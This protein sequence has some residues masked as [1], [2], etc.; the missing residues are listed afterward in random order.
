M[1]VLEI[2]PGIMPGSDRE[3]A[4]RLERALKK[5]GLKVLTQMRYRERFVKKGKVTLKGVQS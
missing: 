5:Q 2:L 1:T 3:S 4:I